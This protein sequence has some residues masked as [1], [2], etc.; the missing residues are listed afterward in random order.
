MAR[1]HPEAYGD[2]A[3]AVRYPGGSRSK[4][5]LCIGRKSSWG[6]AIEFKLLRFLGDNGKPNG[7]MLMHILSPYPQD[8][9]ALTDCSKLASAPIADRKAII[10]F[11]YDHDDWPLEPAVGAFE[12]LAASRV[13][14]G[15]RQESCTQS[16][17]HP[18]HSA[19][20]VYGWE[21]LSSKEF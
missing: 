12:T 10:I 17:V 7:N 9:S 19:G 8:R 11:G 3:R 14:L 2:H 18:V 4:C 1:S 13:R 5:D 20:R 16:L 6:W 15:P 21:L